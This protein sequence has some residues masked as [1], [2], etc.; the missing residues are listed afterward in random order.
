MYADINNNN[1][2]KLTTSAHINITRSRQF[3]VNE[4]NM[5]KGG[6]TPL[7]HDKITMIGL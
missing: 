4:E 3:A 7:S 2:N 1:Q 5:A 6:A